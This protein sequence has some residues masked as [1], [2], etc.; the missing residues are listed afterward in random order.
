MVAL[1]QITAR[2]MWVGV[3]VALVVAAAAGIALAMIAGPV[4]LVIGVVSVI[5]MLGYVGGPV[6]L[7]LPGIGRGVRVLVLRSG[8]DGGQSVHL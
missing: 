6:P 8:G 7:R 4:I 2:Q 1:G 5:A 3:V